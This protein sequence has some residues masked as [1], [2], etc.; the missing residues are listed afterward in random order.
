MSKRIDNTGMSDEELLAGCLKKNTDAQKALF[1]KY[2]ERMMGLCLRYAGSREEAQDYLQEG[3]IKVFDKLGQYNGTGAL[4][5]WISTV[6]VNTALIQ[7]RKKK[8]E[9][10]SE[11][12]DEMYDLSNSDYNV[13]DKMSAA[14][15]MQLVTEMPAGYR[16]VFNLFAIEGYSHKEIAERMKITESTSKTQFHKAKAYLKKQIEELNSL[17]S[18]KVK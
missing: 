6:M 7:I 16:T 2:G 18:H 15:L 1:A 13:L 14:E 10:Y 4:G 12:I 11:D 3:F 17:S 9:G 8:R 5:G